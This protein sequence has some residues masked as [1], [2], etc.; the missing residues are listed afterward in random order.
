M[1][2]KLIKDLI[3]KYERQVEE[4]KNQIVTFENERNSKVYFYALKSKIKG[5]ISDLEGLL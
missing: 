4:I 5:F 3:A 1:K 2:K